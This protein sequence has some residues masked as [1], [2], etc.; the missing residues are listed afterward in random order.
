M[1]TI[2]FTVLLLG[3]F[4]FL[5]TSCVKDD[6]FELPNID[7]TPTT[8]DGTV[9]TLADV[10][11]TSSD[12]VQTYMEN[13]AIEGYVI[14][15]DQ[16]GNYYKKI[17][18]QT[19]DG[20]DGFSVAINKAGLYAEYPVGAKV[21]VRLKDMSVQLINGKLE[22]GYSEYNCNFSSRNYFFERFR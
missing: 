3:L 16:G 12:K 15:S 22:V 6:D 5:F 4:S 11:K 19:L 21:Q 17:Y 1:R 20:T 8:F 18:I 9:V 7:T 10:V 13:N 2:K 14:S